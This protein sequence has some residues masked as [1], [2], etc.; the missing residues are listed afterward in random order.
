MAVASHVCPPSPMHQGGH[1][2]RSIPEKIVLLVLFFR[3]AFKMKSFLS[4]FDD[5]GGKLDVNLIA[6]VTY[7]KQSGDM[8]K[9]F[10]EVE[11][12]Q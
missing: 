1:S 2:G 3:G 8:F 11:S 6:K 4:E 5:L 10:S 7:N 9:I 12:Q